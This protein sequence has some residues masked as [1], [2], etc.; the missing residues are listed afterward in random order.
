MNIATESIT[1]QTNGV[2]GDHIYAIPIIDG[3][4]YPA[5]ALNGKVTRHT[6]CLV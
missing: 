3:D 1:Q 2:K 4:G 6:C 5:I